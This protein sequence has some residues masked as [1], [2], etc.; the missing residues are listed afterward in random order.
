ML[1]GERR[2]RSG[3]WL[4]PVILIGMLGWTAII[5]KSCSAI[6]GTSASAVYTR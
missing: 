3:W 4:V 2:F 1:M 6:A 5:T